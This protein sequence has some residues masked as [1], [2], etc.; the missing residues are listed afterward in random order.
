MDQYSRK[1]NVDNPRDQQALEQ[2][3]ETS[4]LDDPFDQQAL[5]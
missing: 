1:K 5:E 3:F 2:A 4:E